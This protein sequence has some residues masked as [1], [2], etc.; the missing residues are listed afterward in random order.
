M[1]SWPCYYLL[2]TS[3]RPRER[4]FK[5]KC[6]GKQDPR[7]KRRYLPVIIS[8]WR[9]FSLMVGSHE[10]PLKWR[11]PQQA[12][13]LISKVPWTNVG[14]GHVWV[15]V[16]SNT[17]VSVWVQSEAREKLGPSEEHEEC[18]FAERSSDKRIGDSSTTCV[19]CW[20]PFIR[21]IFLLQLLIRLN[22]CPSRKAVGRPLDIGGGFAARLHTVGS[23]CHFFFFL[24]GGLWL[25]PPVHK[26]KWYNESY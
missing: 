1:R 5:L 19:F 3:I 13:S 15:A 10:A 12:V 9:A 25:R 21:K 8:I 23:L 22:T 26:Q 2:S 6:T 24:N 20:Q 17:P 4:G 18:R 16:G 11:S 14:G 7:E